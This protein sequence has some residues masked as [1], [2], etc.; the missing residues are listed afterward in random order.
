MRTLPS[1]L[2][3]KETDEALRCNLLKATSPSAQPVRHSPTVFLFL[4]SGPGAQRC[5]TGPGSGKALFLAGGDRRVEG[6]SSESCG[7]FL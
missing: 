2:A 6:L 7:P 4:G 5:P 1:C 3:D